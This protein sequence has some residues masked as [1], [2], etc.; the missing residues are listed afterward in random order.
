[1]AYFALLAI[2]KL[3]MVCEALFNPP[4]LFPDTLSIREVEVHS[5]VSREVHGLPY[6]INA[7]AVEY[8]TY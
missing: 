2:L 8:A 6:D 4:T 5:G 3:L 7:P 1:M